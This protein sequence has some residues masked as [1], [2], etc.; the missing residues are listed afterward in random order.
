MT[1][2]I[3]EI[4]QQLQFADKQVE[5]VLACLYVL[6]PNLFRKDSWSCRHATR[7]ALSLMTCG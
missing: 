6:M 2:D 5:A 7:L 1:V 4:F 3:P